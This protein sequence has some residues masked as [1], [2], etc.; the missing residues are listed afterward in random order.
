MLS[1]EDEAVQKFR[2][3]DEYIRQ[4]E[5]FK[6]Q[7]LEEIRLAKE[8]RENIIAEINA[9]IKDISIKEV[10]AILKDISI[11]DPTE[12]ISEIVSEFSV[13]FDDIYTKLNDIYVKL[14]SPVVLQEPPAVIKEPP[15]VL[16]E[17]PVIPVEPPVAVQQPLE[18]MPATQVSVRMTDIAAWFAAATATALAI[19]E[20][21]P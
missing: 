13:K 12:K 10:N 15:V 5:E 20:L 17:P 14:D 2:E 3:I 21:I 18:P 11:K 19:K 6:Y 16:Q 9:I 8:Y 4:S 7:A 1:F